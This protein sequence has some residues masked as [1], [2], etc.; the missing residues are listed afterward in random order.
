MT[1]L[2]LTASRVIKAPPE[3]VFNAWIDPAMMSKFMV[4]RPDMQ[5]RDA[6]SD[7]RVGG[8]FY[9]MMVGDKEYPHSGTYKE[10]TPHSRLVFTW[11]TPWSAPESTVM[12]DFNPVAGGTEV[13]LTH[14]RFLSEQSRDNHAQG[15][16]GMLVNLENSL[17]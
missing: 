4:P 10:I 1:D 6:R 7:A 17:K 5:V 15:W 11:E 3:R 16:A 8:T 13:V 14:I 2:T 12:I 9:V